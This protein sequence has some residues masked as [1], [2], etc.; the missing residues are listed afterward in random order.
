[1]TIHKTEGK[2]VKKQKNFIFVMIINIPKLAVLRH[3]K[4][5]SR[6]FRPLGG[7]HFFQAYAVALYL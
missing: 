3:D 1:M 5:H 7:V 4:N 6:N 2:Y